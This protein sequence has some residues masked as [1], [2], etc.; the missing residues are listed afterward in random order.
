MNWVLMMERRTDSGGQSSG[1]YDVESSEDIA[2]LASEEPPAG[3]LNL[4]LVQYGP[5]DKWPWYY[6]PYDVILTTI[7]A[8]SLVCTSNP[9]KVFQYATSNEWKDARECFLYQCTKCMRKK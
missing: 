4:M 1:T 3:T 5:G 6:G 7:W 9:Q 8:G 2:H